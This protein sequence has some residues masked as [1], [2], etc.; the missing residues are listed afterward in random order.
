LH[1]RTEENTELVQALRQCDGGRVQ[2]LVLVRDDFWMAVTRFLRELEIRLVEGQNSAAVDLFP[3]RHAE[4]VLA[5]FGRAFGCLP[6]NSRDIGP[7]QKQFLEQAVA[8]LAR[9]GKVICV[10]LA[11]FA[12]MMRGKSWTPAALRALGGTEGVGVAFLEGTFS[13]AAAAPEHR[14]HQTAARAVLRAL[15]PE[16]GTD[17]KGHMRPRQELLEASGYGSRPKDFDALLHILDGEL[18]LITPTDPQASEP[19]ASARDSGQPLANVS[20]SETERYYQL[21]HDYLVP[22]LRDWLTRKQ[23]ETRRGRAELLLADRAAVW[24]A[25]PENRQLPSLPQWVS[26]RLLTR[27]KDWA[28]PQRHMMRRAGRYH[29]LRGAFLAV[30][31]A[32]LT[33]AALTIRDRVAEQQNEAHA[34]GLVRGLLDADTAQVPAL[35]DELGR[36]YRRW[37]DPLLRQEN[38]RA[39]EG[40]RAKLHTA[41]ALLSV[42]PGQRDFL[43]DRLLGAE[44]HEMAVLRDALW[45]HREELKQRLWAEAEA[46][47]G[48]EGRRLRAAYA[49]AAYDPDSDH[50]A[51][52]AR[53]LARRLVAENVVYLGVWLDG[54]RPVKDHLLAPL[55]EV[56]RDRSEAR[57]GERN[58]A[59]SILEDFA[60]DRPDALADLLMDAND[61]Q[62]A[63]LFPQVQ[64]AGTRAV[65]PL[66]AELD[67]QAAFP[68]DDRPLDP[69]WPPPAGAAMRQVEAAQGLVAERFALCQTLP[70]EQFL[71]V[72]EA[73]RPAGYRPIRVCPFGRGSGAPVLVAALWTRDGRDWR[74]RPDA[75]AAD[76]PVADAEQQRQ[77]YRP[78]DVAGYLAAGAER[79]A[80]LWVRGDDKEEAKLYAGVARRDHRAARQVMRRQELQPATLHV[81]ALPDGEVR[82]S[83]VWRKPAPAGT[84]RWGDSERAYADQLALDAELPIDVGL[85]FSDDPLRAV[86]REAA[87]WLAGA[88]WPMLAFRGGQRDGADPRRRYA[89]TWQADATREHADLLGLDPAA[90]L[91]RCRELA[92]R[93]YRPAALA[94]AEERPG[95]ALRTAS[96]WH[97]PVV[98]EEDKERLAK[99]QASAAV[100]LLRLGR[101]ERVWPLLKHSPDPRVRSYLVHRLSPRGADPEALVRRLGEEPDVTIRRALLLALG[102]FDEGALPPARREALLP[103]LFALYGDDPDAGIHGSAAWLLRH[104]GQRPRLRAIDGELAARDRDLASGRRRPAEGG[105]R[106]YVNGQG[107]TMVLVPGPSAFWMG[108]PRTE[109]EREGGPESRAELRHRTRIGRTYALAAYEVTV[110]QFR[111]FRSD[112]PYNKAFSPTAE[113]PANGVSWHQAAEYCNWLSEQEGIPRSNGATRSTRPRMTR[114][115][116]GRG[117]TTWAWRATACPP[118]RSGNTPVAPARR[119][120]GL[121]AR[122]TSCSADTPGTRKCRP[123]RAPHR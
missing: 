11:L 79:Y 71:A 60:A 26:I 35:I 100:G 39:A 107:Q 110:A 62:F 30:A 56:F 119:R 98:A 42:D 109:R 7:D 91:E 69:A 55:A 83:G 81:L 5:A 96:V 38:A 47:P 6:E 111:K 92:T 51:K 43:C 3:V 4:K 78:A 97:R 18:R 50:W 68:W 87:G 90:H 13:A 65:A 24:S 102:Q 115:G 29:L 93:G 95:Q 53:P 80:V 105:R 112:H 23:K 19:E 17:I 34:A 8:G 27:K 33:V 2:C 121:T 22:S 75:A 106:W 12:E 59:T 113:H 70:L 104:W 40:S 116:C 21:T 114:S 52:V 74:L 9:E 10:R 46:P 25:R 82:F 20:G 61:K 1:A 117:R 89:S 88:P 14:Y 32:A 101:G 36:G 16:A 45:P 67:R 108:S 57:A 103:R 58:L 49:Q 85:W 120:P 118:R 31:V 44:P 94:V 28:P 73:L 99:R 77:G 41:L 54:L 72:A 86:A 64:A 15:L 123:T 84:S 66:L 122:R 37:A 76:V 63:A 48:Q